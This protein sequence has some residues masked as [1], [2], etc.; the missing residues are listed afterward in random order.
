MKAALTCSLAFAFA[1]SAAAALA[2]PSARAVMREHVKPD[3]QTDAQLA[4]STGWNTVRGFSWQ[5]YLVDDLAG[6]AS[7]TRYNRKFRTGQAFKFKVEAH[8]DLW[9]YVMNVEPSGNMVTLLPELGEQHLLVRAGKTV[10]VPPDGHF[11]FTGDGGTERFSIIASPEKLKWVTPE[12]LRKLEGGGTLPPD[13]ERVAMA[14]ARERSKSLA[15]I[16]SVQAKKQKGAGKL[17]RKSLPELVKMLERSPR[18]KAMVKDVVLVPP[19]SEGQ[20]LPAEERDRQDVIFVSEERND[21]DAIV[22]DIELNHAR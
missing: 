19:A 11:R 12:E 15:G 20:T 16:K 17:Y 8:T 6:T 2:Q 5:M 10:T 13:V 9:I 18:M 14:Q 21:P 1:L 3:G 4:S 7:L 22:I